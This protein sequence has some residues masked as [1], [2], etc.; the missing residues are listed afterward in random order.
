MLDGKEVVRAA[1]GDQ[2]PGVGP[3]SVQR[4]RR[5]HRSG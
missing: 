3:L 4:V 1:L 5:D 2:V